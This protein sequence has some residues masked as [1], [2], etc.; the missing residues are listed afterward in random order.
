MVSGLRMPVRQDG[1]PII[2]K[3]RSLLT[4]LL[5]PAIGFGCGGGSGEPVGP[6]PP[7]PV[8]PVVPTPPAPN[9]D[10]NL[11]GRIV[12]TSVQTRGEL[13]VYTV[14]TRD[15]WGLGVNGV[16]PKF[17]PDGTLI[18]FQGGGHGVAVMKSNGTEVRTLRSRGGTP[19]FD[20]TGTVIAFGDRETGVWKINVD[21]T[22]LTS[23]TNDGGF[24]PAW[25]PDGKRI[26]Y[27]VTVGTTQQLFIM[28]ADGSDRRQALT[29]NAIV[30][31]VW[32]PGPK[33]LFGVLVEPLNYELHSYDPDDPSSLVRLTTRAD[34]DFEPSWSPDGKNISWSNIDS[35]LWIMNAD[36][37]GQH[38]VVQAGRQ[39]SW[40]K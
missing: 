27:S 26:V 9:P 36:G 18:A 6:F 31:L 10:A 12:Y 11:P 37:T 1:V 40:G 14:A 35:G 33:I 21:G 24:Q 16:N 32:R 30:D 23:L 3:R 4:V 28:N 34:N 22:G 38:L 17:S 29:S 13:Q 20:P 15:N 39:G 7:A 8:V 25:S 19:S 5:L 2:P